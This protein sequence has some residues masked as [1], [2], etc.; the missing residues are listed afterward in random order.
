MKKRIVSFLLALAL[1]AG[2]LLIPGSALTA[3]QYMD[4]RGRVAGVDYTKIKQTASYRI[5]ITISIGSLAFK[6]WIKN[7]QALKNEE[8]DEIIRQVMWEEGIDS[9]FFAMAKYY[10]REAAKIDPNFNAVAFVE[11]AGRFWGLGTAA[12]AAKDGASGTDIIMGEIE[13]QVIGKLIQMGAEGGAGFVLN[14]LANCADAG[15]KMLMEKISNDDI[16]QRHTNYQLALMKFYSEVNSRIRQKETTSGT[17]QWTMTCSATTQKFVEFMGI[18]VP[19]YWKLQLDMKKTEGAADSYGGTYK[20]SY[21]LDAWHD[22]SKFD[23]DFLEELYFSNAYTQLLRVSGTYTFNDTVQDKSTLTKRISNPNATATVGPDDITSALDGEIKID[24]SFK[25]RQDFW[26]QH[27]IWVVPKNVLWYLNPDG[28]YTLGGGMVT[29]NTCTIHYFE[30]WMGNE[31][32]ADLEISE[33]NLKANGELHVPRAALPGY[34]LGAEETGLTYIFCSDSRMYKDL[35][36][37]CMSIAA[38]WGDDYEWVR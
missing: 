3:E 21:Q 18:R 20:G 8:I 14:G 6:G 33:W 10:E 9:N 11:L 29:G 25:E 24:G 34:D 28:T 31:M 13:G 26:S 37:G 12:D 2:L 32:R 30:G 4:A 17:A 5:P 27:S 15:M 19:Q 35:R 16:I 36:G 23:R 38:G 1:T 7:G 22:L